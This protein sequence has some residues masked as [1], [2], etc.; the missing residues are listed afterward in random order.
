MIQR[1]FVLPGGLPVL[2]IDYL[3]SDISMGVVHGY[4]CSLTATGFRKDLT[5]HPIMSFLF[6]LNQSVKLGIGK[7]SLGQC[8]GSLVRVRNQV[9]TEKTRIGRNLDTCLM[10]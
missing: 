6:G 10:I 3:I 9:R 5:R 8:A 1:E 2:P 7:S 4:R